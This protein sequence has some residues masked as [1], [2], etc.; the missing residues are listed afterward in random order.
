MHHSGFKFPS[1]PSRIPVTFGL[2]A[3]SVSS[4]HAVLPRSLFLRAEH[5]VLG[6]RNCCKPVCR[7]LWREGEHAA[8]LQ[9]GLGLLVNLSPWTVN[10]T[11]AS[12]HPSPLRGDEMAGGGSRQRSLLPHG[13]PRSE[14]H[15]VGPCCQVRRA[16]GSPAGQPGVPSAS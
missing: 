7:N 15:G 8:V 2:D 4:D 13:D 9:L 3:R 14:W 16:L 6:K 11:H 5:Y 12:Q 1:D 10:F